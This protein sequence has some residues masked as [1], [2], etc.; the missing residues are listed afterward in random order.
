M[1]RTITLIALSS[2]ALVLS[3]VTSA[4]ISKTNFVCA[5][6]EQCSSNGAI[7]RCEGEG[8]C[9]FPD[10]ECEDGFRFGDS[11]GDLS[12]LCVGDTGQDGGVTPTICLD[13]KEMALG[14]AHTCVRATGDNVYCWGENSN[15][16]LGDD[17]FVPSSEPGPVVALPGAT[18]LSAGSSHTCAL[19]NEGHVW[20]WGVN[21]NG[22]IGDGG[23]SSGR[24]ARPLPTA[25]S[26]LNNATAISAGSNHSCAV[27]GDGSASCWGRNSSGQLG[28]GNKLTAYAPVP[29]AA[30][31]D[32]TFA[33]PLAEVTAIAAGSAH[34]CAIAAGKVVCWGQGSNGQLGDGLMAESLAPV[35]VSGI[36]GVPQSLTAGLNHTCAL[37]D[38]GGIF[39]WGQNSNGQI[40]DGTS[41]NTALTAKQVGNSLLAVEVSAGNSHT[42]ARTAEGSNFCWGANGNSQ[43]GQ[44]GVEDLAAPVEVMT[45]S[46]LLAAGGRHSCGVEAD[47]SLLCWGSN[48][49]GQLG[50][51]SLLFSADPLQ[52]LAPSATADSV[53]AG[54]THV[55][56]ILGGA[57]HCWGSNSQGQIGDGTEIA[58]GTPVAPLVSMVP[59]TGSS[60]ISL[61]TSGTCSVQ[62]DGTAMCWGYQFN[63]FSSLTPSPYVETIPAPITSIKMYSNQM[64]TVSGA[65]GMELWAEGT[66]SSGEL[67]ILGETNQVNDPRLCDAVTGT[68]Q[69]HSGSN[70]TCA[71]GPTTVSCVGNNNSGALGDNVAVNTEGGPAN[72]VTLPADPVEINGGSTFTCARLVDNS[73]S[74]WGSNGNG[75]LGDGTTVSTSTSGAPV[76]VALPTNDAKRLVAHGAVACA[77]RADDTLWCWG[78]NGLDLFHTGTSETAI[79]TPTQVLADAIKDAAV[80]TGFICVILAADDSLQCWGTNQDAQLGQGRSVV[81]AV[82]SATS[83]VCEAPM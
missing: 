64:L 20:C 33:T 44:G 6:D 21:S 78:H 7:G 34:S 4:C 31:G 43:I 53:S 68:T 41:G 83:I 11:S 80:G 46:I 32:A 67:G 56:A 35:D 1:S 60:K 40:G 69:V 82:P 27:R 30:A 2:F 72:V 65:A 47:G 81:S 22:E 3:A 12:G 17:S 70:F 16:Q 38:T 66:N 75:E 13:I 50:D 10:D 29:V 54:N 37:V 45:G 5:T 55:C 73:I 36:A 62:S 49:R 8:F 24:Y 19:G 42:C 26:M 9:S 76:T 39:C 25:V 51:K 79:T 61:G 58:K 74:C 14:N 28:T 71:L 48:S 57:V 63:A 59:L 15:G 52:V 77:I 18:Q 23:T